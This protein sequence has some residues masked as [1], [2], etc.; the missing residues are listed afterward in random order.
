MRR[1]LRIPCL[2]LAL[3]LGT[4]ASAHG[5]QPGAADS[6]AVRTQPPA[7]SWMGFAILTRTGGYPRVVGV[8]EG[9][10]AAQAGMVEGDTVLAVDG[11]DFVQD[12]ADLRA[13]EPGQ[14][15]TVRVRRGGR[16]LDLVVVP[17]PPRRAAP[18]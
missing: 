3:S 4:A 16:E 5:Q 14:R 18:R 9:S 1:I 2:A 10:P 13:F 12:P 11:K 17:A 15:F 8:L 6:A 7:R